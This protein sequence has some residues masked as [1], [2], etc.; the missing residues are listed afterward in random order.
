MFG[1]VRAAVQMLDQG[2]C[3]IDGARCTVGPKGYGTITVIDSNDTG[4]Q[5]IPMEFTWNSCLDEHHTIAGDPD[6][7]CKC[8]MLCCARVSTLSS[9]CL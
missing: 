4:S 5:E 1:I 3:D 2:Y 6:Y 8:R 7:C 9:S